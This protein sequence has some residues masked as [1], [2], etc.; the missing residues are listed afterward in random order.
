MARKFRYYAKPEEIKQ[1]LIERG[2][3]IQDLYSRYETEPTGL[4]I[5]DTTVR[6]DYDLVIGESVVAEGMITMRNT[7]ITTGGD[8][9]KAERSLK[10]YQKLYR[11]F[12]KPSKS[13]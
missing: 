2:Y 6:L 11:R 10:L 4:A 7:P 12:S 9:E 8:P 3:S 5:V 1:Y 13:S